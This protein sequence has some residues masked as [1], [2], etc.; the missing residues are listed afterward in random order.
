RWVIS[1][2]TPFEDCEALTLSGLGPANL[3]QQ[4]VILTPFDVVEPLVSPRGVRIVRPARWRHACR[5][6]IADTGPA[7]TLRT[8]RKA[9]IDLLTYQ[10]EP[11]LA[12]LRGRSTRI[13]IADEVGLGKTVQ[14]ALIV[15]ELK[16]RGAVSRVLILTPAG[17]REQWVDEFASRFELRLPV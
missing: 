7:D 1:E 5:Q 16:S 3:G 12:V 2:R 11:A 17:L 14:A 10:L 8:A 9:H 13:L 15:A 6:L 4:Q